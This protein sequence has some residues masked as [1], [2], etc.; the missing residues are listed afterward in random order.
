[1]SGVQVASGP[2]AGHHAGF[3]PSTLLDDQ[4][5]IG[6]NFYGHSS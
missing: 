4:C 5:L 3:V 6:T 2:E 1:M